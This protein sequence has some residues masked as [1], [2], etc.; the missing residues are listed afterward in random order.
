MS[1]EEESA[2]QAREDAQWREIVENFGDRAHLETDPDPDP[3]PVE[4]PARLASFFRAPTPPEELREDE[5][6]DAEDA[7]EE[8]D[9]FVPPDP[10][11]VPRPR[12]ARLAAWLGVLG[13]P[14]LVLLLMLVGIRLPGLG[15]VA[16]LAWFAGGF[17]YLVATM[18]RGPG[19]ED[20]WDDGARV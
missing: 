7:L 15:G 6:A 20:G 4:D 9:R 3:R 19:P 2:R 10:P 8:W 17:G 13:V 18:R 16:L 1:R 5:P 12:G 14:P 11:P